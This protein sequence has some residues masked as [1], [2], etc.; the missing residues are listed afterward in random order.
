MSTLEWGP[1]AGIIGP[2]TV[3][4][5]AQPSLCKGVAFATLFASPELVISVID[6]KIGQNSYSD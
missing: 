1:I 6:G 4:M 3:P 5:F 2:N